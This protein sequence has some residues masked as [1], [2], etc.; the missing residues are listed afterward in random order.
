MRTFDGYARFYDTYYAIK[1]YEA[2]CD[3]VLG[4]AKPYRDT[5]IRRILDLGCGTGGHAFPLARKG[6]YV[7]GV[8]LSETMLNTAR[9]KLATIQNDQ[10]TEDDFC[11]ISSSAT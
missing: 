2:E 6:L 3:F 4:V 1:N 7:V 8:D 9:S 10:T 5:A 11:L